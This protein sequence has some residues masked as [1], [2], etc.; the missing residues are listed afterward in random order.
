MFDRLVSQVTAFG[1]AAV[2]TAAM[3]VSMDH[4]ATQEHACAQ[5]AAAGEPAQVVV[6]TAPRLRS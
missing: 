5:A 3:L 1:L 6:I 2:M 4:L